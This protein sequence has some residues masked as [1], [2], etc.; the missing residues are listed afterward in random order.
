MQYVDQISDAT[1]EERRAVVLCAER[2]MEVASTGA[3]P[4]CVGVGEAEAAARGDLDASGGAGDQAGEYVRT[5]EYVRCASR[6]EDAMTAGCDDIFEGAIEAGNFIERTVKGDFH[7]RGEVH[8][9][10]GARRVH[11]ALRV[12]H[13]ENDAGRSHALGVL[14]L[15]ADG[16]E[17][18]C[19]VDESIGVRAQEYVDRE[20][21]AIN[22]LLDKF[23]ARRETADVEHGTEFDAVRAA[24]L[25][26]QAGFKGLGA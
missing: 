22:S 21:A 8:Q 2:T 7:R 5:G 10:A 24:G 4:D 18:G 16:G 23:M 9:S 14:K 11:C 19:G 15:G 1:G 26:R 3:T 25:G 12:Q 17:V 13:A 6:G 20:A